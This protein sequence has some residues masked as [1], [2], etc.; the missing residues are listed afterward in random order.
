MPKPAKFSYLPLVNKRKKIQK[1]IISLLLYSFFSTVLLIISC[2]DST[3]YP[4]VLPVKV[5]KV[6]SAA[7]SCA[8]PLAAEAG[9]KILKAGG[10]AVDA[11]IAVQF[12]L[13]VVYPRAGNLG[14]GG[15]MMVRERNGESHAL[16]FRETAPALA[17]SEMYLDEEKN[18]IPDLSLAGILASGVP[19]TVAGM[20]EAYKK[21]G[22]FNM[23]D[24]IM[25]AYLIA[26]N[27]FAIS[28]EEADRLNEFQK[29]F[30]ANNTFGHP[31]KK[32]HWSQGD[33]LIQKNLAKTLEI[34]MHKGL[35]DFYTG[36]IAAIIVK[37]FSK[38]NG[39]ITDKDLRNYSAQW[40]T[41]LV[42]PYKNHKI[43]TMPPPSSGG[44]ALGQIFGILSHYDPQEKNHF[45][46]DVIHFKV[47][48]ERRAFA[49]RSRFLGDPDFLSIPSDSLL[50]D[51]TNYNNFSGIDPLRATSSDIYAKN[52]DRIPRESFETTHFSI[53]DAE[54]MAVALTTTLNSNYG[55]KVILEEGGFF[56]N[57]EM[58]DFVSKPGE[59]NQFGL[60]GSKHN[61]IQPGKRML[62]SMTPTIVTKD[63]E[64]FLVVGTPG[65]STIITTVYQIISNIIDHGMGLEESI[66]TKRFHHQWIPDMIIYEEGCFDSIVI[67]SLTE[68]GHRL[69]Q[70]ER[71]GLVDA[72]EI[73]PDKKIIAVADSRSEDSVAGY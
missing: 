38:R 23:K 5:I 11:A 13:A 31:F 33:I 46:S 57:N 66:A 16:D 43:I 17:H 14:G 3:T 47:E 59:P 41:P 70:A 60:L 21:F 67:N 52:N 22:S 2:N 7:V 28:V 26:L 1:I 27:G 64:L 68:K 4:A 24:L 18:I 25:P 54:G 8:H 49:D 45:A 71:I 42:I 6:D 73:S 63:E 39:L 20:L 44:I 55:S 35:E 61:Q 12:V 65:G 53:I 15:F 29:D 51:R 40:R 48:A 30:N 58:D 69:H 72:I 34:L 50:S 19:G 36:E 37:E 32:N 10:N 62:S 56:M 9:V